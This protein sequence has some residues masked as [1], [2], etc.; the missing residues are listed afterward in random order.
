MSAPV[1]V[2]LLKEWKG[3]K[4]LGLNLGSCCVVAVG[5]TSE[6][7]SWRPDNHEAGEISGI[8]DDTRKE[9]TA[10]VDS[11]LPIP[12]SNGTDT[13][14][15]SGWRGI[16]SIFTQISRDSS[17]NTGGIEEVGRIR[18][19]SRKVRSSQYKGV[20]AQPNGR[21]GAQIY[22]KHRRIWLGTFN[23]EEDAARS[24][25]TAALKFRGRR[26]ITNFST[27]DDT[28]PEAIFLGLHS[29]AEIV[30]MLRTHTYREELQDYY[31]M[32]ATKSNG[33]SN[34]DG[35]EVKSSAYPRRHLFEKILTP[36]DVGKL[37]RL[38]IP[39][40]YAQSCLPLEEASKDKGVILNCEDDM[41]K[42][43]RFKY[44]YWNSSQSYVLTKGW[45]RYTKGKSLK[46]GDIVSFEC[47]TSGLR[48]LY[49]SFRRRPCN[50][51]KKQASF[52]TLPVHP[53][54][55]THLPV[56]SE[57]DSPARIEDGSIK[58]LVPWLTPTNSSSAYDFYGLQSSKKSASDNRKSWQ[59]EYPDLR[60]RDLCSFI[61]PDSSSVTVFGVNL[62]L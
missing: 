43:W 7:P 45:C 25:D 39:K 3:N 36:S 47:S 50:N 35:V 10:Q 38:V 32:N 44:S 11:I 19:G 8:V 52:S 16:D 1:G 33:S 61:S 28:H 22:E 18:N 21:W 41:G 5:K 51:F 15:C 6:K 2:S 60:S 14:P 29:K 46:A 23:N 31:K 57:F 59:L 24:Y 34:L 13:I 37:N 58:G 56:Y 30:D 26:A 48:Q 12:S 42:I 20:L 54:V 55:V 53:T 4:D 40:L 62:R 17:N 27:I 9:F 49:I